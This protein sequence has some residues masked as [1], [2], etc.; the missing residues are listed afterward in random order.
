MLKSKWCVEWNFDKLCAGQLILL[1]K[2]AKLK[3]DNWNPIKKVK[4]I[5]QNISDKLGVTIGRILRKGTRRGLVII[6]TYFFLLNV[7]RWVTIVMECWGRCFVHRICIIQAV[8]SS[9]R[10]DTFLVIILSWFYRKVKDAHPNIS[11]S[12][13]SLTFYHYQIIYSI[14]LLFYVVIVILATWKVNFNVKMFRWL[15]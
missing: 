14:I 8:L 11:Y 4:M 6:D 9:G 12:N 3:F 10:R 2:T 15:K 7:Y 13:A 5:A 1:C